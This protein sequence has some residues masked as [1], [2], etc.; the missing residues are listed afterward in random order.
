VIDSHAHN[1]NELC[2]LDDFGI[3]V[4]RRGWT[5]RVQVL[6][7]LPLRELRAALKNGDVGRHL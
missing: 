4:A 1:A 2:C 3:A 7:T 6:N 5:E